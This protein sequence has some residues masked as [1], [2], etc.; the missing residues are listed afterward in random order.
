MD[1]L[2]SRWAQ[3]SVRTTGEVEE[4]GWGRG[5]R[6][7]GCL[8][9]GSEPVAAACT[10]WSDG[11]AVYESKYKRRSELIQA[12]TGGIDKQRTLPRTFGRK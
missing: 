12:Q 9:Y 2:T 7:G 1:L 4:A 8:R 5:R 10:A 11:V 3:V 6:G